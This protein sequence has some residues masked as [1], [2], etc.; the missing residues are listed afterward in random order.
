MNST[1]SLGVFKD[2]ESLLSSIAGQYSVMSAHRFEFNRLKQNQQKLQNIEVSNKKGKGGGLD[3]LFIFLIFFGLIEIFCAVVN[4][5]SEQSEYRWILMLFGVIIGL[6]FCIPS[7][8]HF[9]VSKPK[10]QKKAKNEVELLQAETNKLCN[11]LWN[12]YD[13]QCLKAIP[14]EYSD[15]DILNGLY[16]TAKQRGFTRVGDTINCYLEQQHI[17]V[18]SDLEQQAYNVQCQCRNVMRSYAIMRL[19]GPRKVEVRIH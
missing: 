13:K 10:N 19:V 14:F 8:I 9:C 15:P 16:S 17:N 6:A 5:I 18:M 7:I 11:T 1:N 2:N 3:A 12:V 4:S